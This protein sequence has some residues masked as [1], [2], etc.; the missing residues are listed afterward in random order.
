MPD[1]RGVEPMMQD[2]SGADRFTRYSLQTAATTLLLLGIAAAL[3]GFG[4][5]WYR[6]GQFAFTTTHAVAA[7][8]LVC[9]SLHHGYRAGGHRL[10]GEL[11]YIFNTCIEDYQAQVNSLLSERAPDVDRQA[12]LDALADR[13]KSSL[14]ESLGRWPFHAVDLDW[15]LRQVDFRGGRS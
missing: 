1:A 15:Q 7:L 2:N 6:S 14:R 8:V 11:M 3:V 13:T 5:S 10:R 12:F 4:F 9:I